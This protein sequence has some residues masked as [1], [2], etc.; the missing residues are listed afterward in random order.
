MAKMYQAA[1]RIIRDLSNRRGLRQA[2]ED[3]DEEVR[4]EIRE[5]WAKLIAASYGEE[6]A[7]W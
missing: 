2:W 5:E 6:T 3:I 4:E 7:D 1:D